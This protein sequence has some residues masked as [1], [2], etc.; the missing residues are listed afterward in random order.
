MHMFSKLMFTTL[1]VTDPDKALAFYR[2]M[3][4][5]EKRGDNP[6]PEGRFLLIGLKG[7]DIG[8]VLWPGTE[9]RGNATPGAPPL[10][11]PGTLF[12]ESDDLRKDFEALRSRGLEFGHEEPEDY[13]FGMRATVMDPDGN[14]ISLRQTR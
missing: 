4:G 14:R 3:F 7:Q 2:D 9:G 10:A 6:G 11:L 13:A 1:F 12:I 5:F 8:V